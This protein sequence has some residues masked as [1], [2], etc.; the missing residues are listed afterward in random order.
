V[1]AGVAERLEVQL[2]YAIGVPEPLSYAIATFGT[3][4]YSDEVILTIIKKLFDCRPGI[5]IR[6]FSLTHPKFKYEDLA[7]YGHFGRP[8]M[9]LRGKNS[10]KS[11][12]SR[13]YYPSNIAIY[14]A[15]L[16][17]NPT[18]VF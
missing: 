3:S 13:R 7:C 4:H 5:I 8:D 10:I 14:I 18:K 17:L 2:S 12:Q 9:D 15:K 11:K 6:D 16:C 1:A